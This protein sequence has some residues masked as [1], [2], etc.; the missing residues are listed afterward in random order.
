MLDRPDIPNQAL[1]STLFPFEGTSPGQK[2][3]HGQIGS[4]VW[5]L[6]GSSGGYKVRVAM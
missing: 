4:F 2:L 1:S 6:T 5:N 3:D